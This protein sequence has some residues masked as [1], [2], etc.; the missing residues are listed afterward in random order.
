MATLSFFARRDSITANNSILNPIGTNQAPTTT[1]TFTDNGGTGDLLLDR[2]GG[3]VDPDTQVIINGVTYN[4]TL[5]FV[6]TFPAGSSQVPDSLEGKQVALITV[7]IGGQTREYFFVTDGTATLAQMNAIGNGSIPLDGLNFNPDPF[8]PCFC[9]GT[10]IATP[11]GPRGVETLGAGDRVLTDTGASRPILWVGKS[12]VSLAELRANPRLAPVRVPAHSFGPSLPAADLLVSPQHRIVLH[13][14]AA[15]LLFAAPRV[16]AAARHLVGTFAEE[17]TPTADVDYFH[18][19]TDAHEILL[20]NGLPS[21]S[22]QPARRSID[23]MAAET[24]AGLELALQGAG[25]DDLL[26]RPDALPSL[27]RGE[28]RALVS[29][30]RP[31]APARPSRAA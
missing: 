13:H 14:P 23:V 7:V 4:F 9:A 16:L 24:R 6:G 29:E 3:L 18:I 30:M 27:R 28:V 19:L 1:I 12:R 5:Q 26:T 11:T 22:F 25:R 10:M 2:N 15:E 31:H 21:E 17:T 8:Y 20:S